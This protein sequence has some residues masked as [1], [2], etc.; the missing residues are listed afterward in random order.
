MIETTLITH[1]TQYTQAWLEILPK[2]EDFMKE[3]ASDVLENE[4]DD[5]GQ[6]DHS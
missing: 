2:L 3:H 1:N 4:E 5:Y 6:C